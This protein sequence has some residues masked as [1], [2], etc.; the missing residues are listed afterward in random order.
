[1]T[2]RLSALLLAALVAGPAAADLAIPPPKGKKFVNV[3]S[4]VQL[5]KDVKGYVFVLQ[6]W[7][8]PGRPTSTT[9]K[10]D[11][12]DAKATEVIA[13]GRRN[14][15]ALYAVPEAAAKEFKTDKEL[16]DAVTARKVKGVQTLSLPGNTAV[17]DTV[18]GD[19]VRW[20]Y[21]ITGIDDK[22]I[23]TDVAGDGV[24]KKEE[25]KP[26]EKKP[27]ALAEP[28]YLIGGVAAA[29]AVAFGG[30]WLARRRKVG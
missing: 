27:L 30:L 23:K 28:G 19:A 5:G 1:M 12:T 9:T 7:K 20:T 16:F 10:I 4:E 15:G 21:T 13:G 8:G 22:G 24:E 3:T 25:K 6:E 14:S 2:R 18:K 17:S 26:G 29:L 11:L